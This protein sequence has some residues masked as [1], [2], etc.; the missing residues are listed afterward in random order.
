MPRTSASGLDFSLQIVAVLLWVLTAMIGCVM[1]ILPFLTVDRNFVVTPELSLGNFIASWDPVMVTAIINSVAL[2]VI[3]SVVAIVCGGMLT[4]IMSRFPVWVGIGLVLVYCVNPI[5]RALSFNTLFTINTPIG[6]WMNVVFGEWFAQQILLP[7]II[8]GAHYLPIYLMRFL[9]V[10]RKPTASHTLKGILDTVFVSVPSFV[11]GF[12]ISFAI[13]FLL[14]FFD[15]WVIQVISGGKAL[16]W[17]QMFEQKAFVARDV[18]QAGMLIILGLAITVAAYVAAVLVCEAVRVAW[19]KIRPLAV[20]AVRLPSGK[21]T[22]DALSILT[23]LFFTW[24]VTYSVIRLVSILFTGESWRLLDGGMRS[25]FLTLILSCAIAVVSTILSLVFSTYYREHPRRKR[26]WLPALYF[27]AL[28][29]EA[30]YVLFSLCVTGLGVL[31]ASP[32]WLFLLMT[33]FSMPMSFFL[34]E[35]LWGE[36][37]ERKLW[38]LASAMRGDVT[39]SLL[40]ALR[41]WKRFVGITFIINLW[42]TVDNVF[43]TNFAA[44]PKWKPLSAVMFSAT[45]RGF[46]DD[47]FLTGS[48]GSLVMLLVIAAIVWFGWRSKEDRTQ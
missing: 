17:S 35:S 18:G 5:T 48:L 45:K 4:R 8:L 20:S 11:R 44:G 41:E 42:L 9:F 43:I 22:G 21:R 26:W 39:K 37:E 46:Q 33:S 6:Q 31:Q 30:G 27:L 38:T 16:Y 14:T 10:I 19:K 12:P 29:P 15:Y 25:V 32:A 3:A 7:A 13:F 2:S 34:W 23:L 1:L 47:K 40:L 24:P 28:V 36:A